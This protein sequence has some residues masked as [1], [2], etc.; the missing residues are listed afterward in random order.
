MYSAFSA[1]V[2]V[3]SEEDSR[4]AGGDQTATWSAKL[5]RRDFAFAKFP[6]DAEVV[7]ER[8]QLR[9]ENKQYR[10]AF[11]TTNQWRVP[12]SWGECWVVVFGPADATFRLVELPP[13]K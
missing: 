2:S 12:D 10:S 6:P 7:P 8:F 13:A 1:D 3:V 11:D 5:L 9:C 4:F